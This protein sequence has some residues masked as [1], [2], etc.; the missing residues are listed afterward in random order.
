MNPLRRRLSC[1]E[2]LD[3]LRSPAREPAVDPADVLRA[4]LAIED[5][6]P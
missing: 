1:L 6:G 3:R 4:M 5:S 2:A